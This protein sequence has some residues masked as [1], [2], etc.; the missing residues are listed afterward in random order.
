MKDAAVRQDL[1]LDNDAGGFSILS[2]GVVGAV[3]RDGHE[4]DERFLAAQQVV[5][6]RLVGDDSLVARVVVGAALTEAESQEW[7]A[8]IR[9]PLVVSGGKLILCAGFDTDCLADWMDGDASGKVQEVAVPDGEYLADIYTYLHSM[10]GRTFLE[11]QWQDTLGAW[12]RRDHQTRP[13]PAWIASELVRFP[14]NDPGH[15]KAWQELGGSVKAGKLVV[16]TEPLG[17]VG[18]LIHLQP[19]DPAAALSS[20]DPEDG[21]WFA[22][23]TGLRRPAR[24][25]LGVPSTVV[26]PFSEVRNTLSAILPAAPP[27]TVEALDILARVHDRPLT[28]VRGGTV[29]WPVD[30]LGDVYR[31]AFLATDSSDPEILIDFPEGAPRPD[32]HPAIEGVAIR[33]RPRGLRLGF[34]ATS[35][36]WAHAR[37][38]RL[39]AEQLPPLPDGTILELLTA[40]RPDP[41]HHRDIGVHRYR[42][43]VHGGIWE[44]TEGYPAVDRGELREA[45]DFSA[46]AGDGL[47]LPLRDAGEGERARALAQQEDYLYNRNPLVITGDRIGLTTPDPMLLAFVAGY[48]FRTRWAQLWPSQ[49]EPPAEG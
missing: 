21:G 8:R 1:F 40:P 39:I 26:P 6:V 45:L 46:L 37:A 17:W 44:I 31:L 47:S 10:N 2:A 16:E 27:P 24:C 42:G 15:E 35:Q 12:F 9:A 49:V 33:P 18:F 11:Q 14:E 25:P 20:A 7:I 36:R 30:K 4:H 43:P 34:E 5:L 48:V 23:T 41:T 38:I 28:P 3:I 13:F 22:P 19:P 32:W 29:E